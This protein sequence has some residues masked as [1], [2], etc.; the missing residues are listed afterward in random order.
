MSIPRRLAAS[1]AR[2]RTSLVLSGVAVLVMLVGV[3]VATN[4]DA[5]GVFTF[6]TEHHHHDLASNDQSGSVEC[7][8]SDSTYIYGGYEER[9]PYW[10]EIFGWYYEHY[11]DWYF[12]DIYT[13]H[14]SS[15]PTICA[16]NEV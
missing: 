12:P 2:G 3:A 1:T 5:A 6:A 13:Y 9:G 11:H 7:G 4:V 14:H 15:D 16:I 10:D 8:I